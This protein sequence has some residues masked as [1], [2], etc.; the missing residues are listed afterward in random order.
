MDGSEPAK[1]LLSRGKKH[2]I[3]GMQ[4]KEKEINSRRS[5]EGGALTASGENA[6]KAKNVRLTFKSVWD[7]FGGD[8][9]I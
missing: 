3:R 9:R 1:F 7:T 6:C 2:H 8:V 5:P 4:R